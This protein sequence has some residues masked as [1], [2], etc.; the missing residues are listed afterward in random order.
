MQLSHLLVVEGN[1]R[2]NK[3]TGLTTDV[4]NIESIR[5]AAVCQ[6]KSTIISCFWVAWWVKGGGGSAAMPMPG[7]KLRP[8]D[9]KEHGQDSSRLNRA[10]GQRWL[11]HAE[12]TWELVQVR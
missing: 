6:K 5:E 8:Y 7:L 1:E 11:C 4:P 2:W 10:M 3:V 9:R 12:S